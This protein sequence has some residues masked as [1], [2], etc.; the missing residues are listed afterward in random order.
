MDNEKMS[1]KTIIE[2]LRD[3]LLSAARYNPDD[4]VRPAAILWTDVDRQWQPV[5]SQLQVLMPELFI[6]GEYLPE[7]KTGPAIWLRCVIDRTLP[8]VG[9]PENSAIG[10]RSSTVM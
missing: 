8:E 5:V 7:K 1:N 2:A 4:V 9:V 3:S 6:L 10:G